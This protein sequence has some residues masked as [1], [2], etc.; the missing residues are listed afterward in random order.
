MNLWEPLRQFR[1]SCSGIRGGRSE[2]FLS[3]QD[4]VPSFFSKRGEVWGEVCH[5]TFTQARTSVVARP[6]AFL[7]LGSHGRLGPLGRTLRPFQKKGPG[8]DPTT[9]VGLLKSGGQERTP[10]WRTDGWGPRKGGVG[11]FSDSHTAV[12]SCTRSAPGT[13][14]G[15]RIFS[16]TRS[17]VRWCLSDPLE[18]GQRL[19]VKGVTIYFLAFYSSGQVERSRC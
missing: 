14:F 17:R 19:G 6:R 5:H 2:T 9:R 8:P 11:G 13:A 4:V 7:R 3:P 18:P 10:P 12:E 1:G 15:L 16:L